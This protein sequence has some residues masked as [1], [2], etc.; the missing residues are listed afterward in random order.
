MMV[1]DSSI[2]MQKLWVFKD[3]SY[4]QLGASFIVAKMECFTILH[5]Q[6]RNTW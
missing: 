2:T 5:F 3:Y 1:H 4:M 6:A